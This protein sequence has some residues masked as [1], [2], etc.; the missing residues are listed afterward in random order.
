LRRVA[1]RGADN[2]VI[3]A[4][5][6]NVTPPIC[7]AC[8]TPDCRADWA[9]EAQRLFDRAFDGRGLSCSA[10]GRRFAQQTVHARCRSGWWWS[11]ARHSE[12][13]AVVQQLGFAKF[14]AIVQ[15]RQRGQHII[16][17]AR[18]CERRY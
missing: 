10:R 1:I 4:P 6:S 3:C 15:G 12:E 7:V 5:G 16:G 13:N 18:R 8:D 2:S 14:A 17:R 11:R 9:R